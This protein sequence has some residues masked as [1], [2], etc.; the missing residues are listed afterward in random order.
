MNPSVLQL[1]ARVLAEGLAFPESPRW[2]NGL[3]WFSDMHDCAVMTLD[4]DGKMAVRH[5]VEHQPS[6]LGWLP[7]GTLLI[8]SMLD[9]RVLRADGEHLSCVADLHTLA[10]F[11]CN[12]MVVDALGRAYVGNFGYD[13]ESHATRASTRLLRVDPD[14]S[15]HVVADDLWFPNG[16]VITPDGSTL[17]VAETMANRLTAFHIA[18]DGGLSARRVWASL[19]GAT[20]DG[21]CLDQAG[22]I[23]IA[24]PISAEVLRVLPGGVIT[25]RVPV[26]DQAIACML[27]G[28]EGRTLYI[29]SAPLARAAKTRVLRRGRI[30]CIEV[31]EGAAGRP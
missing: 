5:R 1:E 21:I 13:F 18:P 20:P 8:V 25:H 31:E 9:R 4:S 16:M 10:A 6:G 15:V 17:V 22:A 7:D 14:G 11:H 30:S 3:L 19:D 26:A 28:P 12:D 27:G 24:S 29:L 2:R 23:W